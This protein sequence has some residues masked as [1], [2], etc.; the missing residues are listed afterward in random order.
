MIL[1]G[2]TDW[3]QVHDSGTPGSSK[4]SSTYPES[5]AEDTA[6]EFFMD[7]DAHGGERWSVNFGEDPASTHIVVDTYVYLL[8]PGQVQN[9]EIDVNQVMSDGR[10]VIYGTQCSGVSNT[11]EYAWFSKRDNW[12][13]T[14]IGCN[15][16]NWE[17]KV[18]HH[19][20]I[21]M[22]RD[23]NGVVT[24]DWVS[25]DGVVSTFNA[26]P[27]NAA[28]SIGWAPGDLVLNYQMEGE[29]GSGSIT[30]YAR[31]ITVYRW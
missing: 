18:W 1:D 27:R 5:I 30:S 6:R 4:G 22:H 12:G 28:K 11:W 20:Q 7:Y 8:D 19:I 10:T 9:L 31:S 21:A 2:L 24:H 13:S 14:K 23:E 15:P 17:P 26:Q 29:N 3:I 16:R 25:L